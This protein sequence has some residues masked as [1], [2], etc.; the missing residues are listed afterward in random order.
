MDNG[1]SERHR[2]LPEKAEEA[3]L[4]QLADEA[5]SEGSD[6]SVS[7]DEMTSALRA[8]RAYRPN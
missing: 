1:D 6:G 3:W 8:H 5:G 7:L 2:T 4:Y